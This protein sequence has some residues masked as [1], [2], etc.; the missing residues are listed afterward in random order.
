[1]DGM[2]IKMDLTGRTLD[3]FVF[4]IYV[5]KEWWLPDEEEEMQGPE[6]EAEPHQENGQ[7]LWQ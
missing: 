7:W 6:G 4:F 2:R 3:E 1:M 5:S